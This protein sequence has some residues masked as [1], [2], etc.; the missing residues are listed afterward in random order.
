MGQGVGGP[1]V[2]GTVLRV[3]SDP[4]PGPGLLSRR[5]LGSAKE[6]GRR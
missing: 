3:A 2:R 5:L 6:A 1:G 4:S